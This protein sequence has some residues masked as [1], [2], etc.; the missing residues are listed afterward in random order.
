MKN[1]LE[2]QTKKTN[3]FC[4]GFYLIR[5]NFIYI[6]FIDNFLH[7]ILGRLYLLVPDIQPKL[8]ICLYSAY[9]ISI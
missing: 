6:Y 4:V 5:L 2:G 7:Q 1:W 9:I 3:V 8:N